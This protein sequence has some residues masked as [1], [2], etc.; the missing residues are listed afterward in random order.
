[1]KSEMET[2]PE[3]SV[4]LPTWN[5]MGFDYLT[6]L[7]KFTKPWL[8]VFGEVDRVVPS[9]ASIRNIEHYMNLSGSK[10]CDIAVIPQCGHAPVNIETKRL[11]RIDHLILNWLDQN[12]A[13]MRCI[14]TCT[15]TYVAN[16]GF[17]IETPN[18][19]ILVDALFGDIRGNWCD[20][21]GDSAANLMLKGIPPFDSVD[22]VLVTHKHADHFKESMVVDFMIN[23][24]RSVLI[25][26]DQVNE[27]LKQNE[28]YPKVSDRIHFFKSDTLFD[29]SL[30]VNNIN[31]RALRFKHGFET[32]SVSGQKIDLHG[33]IENFGYLVEADGFR[34][35]HT[36]DCNTGNISQFTKYKLFNQELDV[37][38]FDRVFLRPEG[39]NV[40]KQFNSLKDLIFMHVEPGRRQYYQSV[41]KDIPSFCIFSNQGERKMLLK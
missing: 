20:Q 36:G 17:L 34:L 30:P 10:V 27:L 40:I 3:F 37:A 15:V 5:S 12:I 21:P 18:H 24:P 39:M 22:V 13:P 41:I 6:E 8:A 23:N 28:S 2:I 19:K 9:A 32:D 4:V 16:E 33:D 38:F 1:M 25:C 31:I 26:P 14:E 11:I 7:S 29:S 35:L